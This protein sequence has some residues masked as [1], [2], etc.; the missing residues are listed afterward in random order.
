VK[1]SKT[2]VFKK[3]STSPQKRWMLTPDPGSIRKRIAKDLSISE[4]TARIL[5]SRLTDP[6]VEDARSF[7]KPSLINLH[8]PFK[9][10]SMDLAVERI[11]KAVNN[12]E[13]IVIYGDYDSDGVTAS[14]L[15]LQVF[16]ALG[17]PA[18]FY[19]PHRIEE[20][21]GLSESF[22][23]QAKKDNINL[24]ITVDCGVSNF[25]EVKALQDTGIDVIVT[26]HHEPGSDCEE[27]VLPEAVAVIN[28]KRKDS[29]YPFRELAGVGVAFK[30]AWAIFE[31]LS[32]GDKVLPHY[33]ETL[34]NI[35]PYV[36][37]GT[38][39][40]VAPLKG[41]NRVFVSWGLDRLGKA[42]VPGL[43]SLLKVSGLGD[44]K[45]SVRDVAF[46]LGPRI[47]AAGRMQNA[48]LALEVLI[49]EDEAEGNIKAEELNDENVRRQVLCQEI[50]EQARS[51]VNTRIELEKDIALTVIGEN[52]H[53][54]VIGIVA[55]RLVDE[56]KRPAVVIAL[57]ED[58]LRGKGSA[59][60][61]PGLNLYEAIGRSRQRFESFGGHEMAAGFSLV[62]DQIEPF[63][64]EFNNECRN[65]VI[66]KGLEPE[67][68][69]DLDVH[70]S[71]LSEGF[72][73]EVEL[74][75]PFG[76][77]NESPRFLSRHVKVAGRPQ[78]M[79]KNG[80]HFSFFASQDSVAFRAVV[81]NH[82]EWLDRIEQGTGYWDIVY[83]LSLNDYYDPARLELRIVDMR[84]S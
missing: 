36:A 13:K 60:S 78:A 67:L 51:Y 28:P 27:E 38:I 75:A 74:L 11:E 31:K 32:G 8:G 55:S 20:G 41:E 25:T 54:G 48:N 16:K 50:Y 62:R 82:I 7:L 19:L 5:A 18:D 58:G 56:F 66:D 53:E 10:K 73:E 79:G 84:P 12:K 61:I 26:D 59:R 42:N 17:H 4:L 52:W 30:L 23:R 14:A 22:I 57:G 69:I 65:Q 33:R 72:A 80:Q 6:G 24:V 9:L 47:N 46:R 70:L 64:Q 81:F 15:L 45:L 3:L 37:L 68:I 2:G 39:T 77:G 63:R 43:H 40:D 44:K 29:D 83:E 21:Y 71:Q 49:A 34:L 35:L 76:A 1:L